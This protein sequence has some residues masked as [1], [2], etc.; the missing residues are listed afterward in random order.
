[1]RYIVAGYVFVLT[2]LFLYAV[3]LAWRR[4]RLERAVARVTAASPPATGTPLADAVARADGTPDP[5]R[6]AGSV[7]SVAPG[8]DA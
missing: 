3:S 7:A 8:G 6:N 2:V 4:R 1:M 5:I